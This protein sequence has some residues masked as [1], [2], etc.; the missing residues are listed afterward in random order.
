MTEDDKW[1]ERTERAAL[2]KT[3]LATL[4]PRLKTLDV[5]VAKPPPAKSVKKDQDETE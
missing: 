1:R 3:G 2:K 5:F 4:K